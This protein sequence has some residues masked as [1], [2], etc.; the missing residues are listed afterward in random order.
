MWP[1]AHAASLGR[2]GIPVRAHLAAAC[3]ARGTGLRRRLAALDRAATLR[4]AGSSSWPA[5]HVLPGLSRLA[6]HGLLWM[7]LAAALWAT[8]NRQ[9]RRAAWRG[10]GSMADAST[11][12]SVIAKGLTET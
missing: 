12:A 4:V 9:A 5:G 11:A 2:S 3:L 8:G 6:D 1:R 10:L 7:V